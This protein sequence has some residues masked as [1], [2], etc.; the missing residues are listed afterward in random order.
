V[1]SQLIAKTSHKCTGKTLGIDG[2]GKLRVSMSEEHRIFLE[3]FETAEVLY[4]V[5]SL[6]SNPDP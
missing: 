6:I 1:T 5:S 4:E 3:R 2:S